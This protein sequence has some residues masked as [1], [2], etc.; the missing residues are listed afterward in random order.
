MNTLQKYDE[1]KREMFS[2][3]LDVP[4]DG[5][6]DS[7]IDDEYV[8]ECDNINKNVK[9][10]IKP[11][12]RWKISV[13][14]QV[15]GN[16]E[17]LGYLVPSESKIPGYDFDFDDMLIPIQVVSGT[18]VKK[19]DDIKGSLSTP[20]VIHSHGVESCLS[21]FSHMDDEYI[22]ENNDVSILISGNDTIAEARL[23]TPCGKFIK[24]DN[25]NI[26]TIMGE[27]ITP[28]L[29]K[30]KEFLRLIKSNIF[31]EYREMVIRE[32]NIDEYKKINGIVSNRK[33]KVIQKE[34]DIKEEFEFEK[35]LEEFE[36]YIENENV[37]KGD[38]KKDS[39]NFTFGNVIHFSKS[40]LKHILRK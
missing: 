18:R 11:F 1:V 26:E 25:K 3:Y 17:W 12:L 19:V 22:N 31:V 6:W 14:M 21:M 13:L 20:Y 37:D 29:S 10:N 8:K 15:F 38:I 30:W 7:G 35:E 24:V 36:K 33:D 39:D 27:K 2:D 40:M 5:I 16:I 9:I 28:P 23:K 4:K 32:V 34:F